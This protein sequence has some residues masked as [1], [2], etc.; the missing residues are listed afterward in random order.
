M[1]RQSNYRDQLFAAV[2][3][4]PC[5]CRQDAAAIVVK[6][7]FA[8]GLLIFLDFIASDAAIN[9]ALSSVAPKNVMEETK[10]ASLRRKSFVR[11]YINVCAFLSSLLQ[12]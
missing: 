11:K 8:I 3:L 6:Y 1:H 4:M 9:V 7:R 5:T 12:L 10:L 2:R